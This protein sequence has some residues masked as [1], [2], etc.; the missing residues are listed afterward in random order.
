MRCQYLG[1][2]RSTSGIILTLRV[3][4][5]VW[6]AVGVQLVGVVEHGVLV[7]V[8]DE[9]EVVVGFSGFLHLRT[10]NFKPL[11]RIKEQKDGL[12]WD[13]PQQG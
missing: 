13:W 12:T 8:I 5:L 1:K 10:V 6:V 7:G 4:G 11:L 9:H 3:A 2:N